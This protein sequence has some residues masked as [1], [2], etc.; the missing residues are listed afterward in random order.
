VDPIYEYFQAVDAAYPPRSV[1]RHHLLRNTSPMRSAKPHT[2][3]PCVRPHVER[4]MAKP[5]VRT[6]C[7]PHVRMLQVGHIHMLSPHDHRRGQKLLLNPQKLRYAGPA[8]HI[9]PSC[10]KSRTRPFA[11]INPME[12]V[13]GIVFAMT[14]SN[15]HHYILTA[16]CGSIRVKKCNSQFRSAQW[17]EP[18]PSLT[19]I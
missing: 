11:C 9:S 6:Q 8:V 5:S 3:V 18:A 1:M 19:P 13:S 17:A 10:S 2:V 7:A 15:F 14:P 4:T 12:L 16:G